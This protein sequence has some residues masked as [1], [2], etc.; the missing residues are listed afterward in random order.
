[1]PPASPDWIP[2]V[3]A[4]RLARL[5]RDWRERLSLKQEIVAARI[6]IGHSTLSAYETCAR[7]IPVPQVEKLLDL[8]GVAG[9]ERAEILQIAA[10]AD[11]VNWWNRY[12]GVLN[13]PFVALE[14]S[15]REICIWA[16]RVVPGLFQTI[17]YA[18]KIMRS[19]DLPYAEDDE[20]RLDARLHR[21]KL[22]SRP[23]A[24]NLRIILD[25]ALLRHPIGTPGEWREQLRRL[26]RDGERPKVALQVLPE[27][28]GEHPGLDGPF[29]VLRFDG[30]HPDVAYAEGVGGAFYLE[31]PAM[32]DPCNLKFEFLCGKALDPTRSAELIERVVRDAAAR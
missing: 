23:D 6:S 21:Q 14:D 9:P 16:P 13:G 4:K 3:R 18:R 15:A 22:L 1:M 29:T 20:R 2:S 26:L 30:D 32:V 11:Q 31:S 25:E 5:L 7:R 19:S 27:D 28:C 10:E 24:P 12:I 17:E 8:Y